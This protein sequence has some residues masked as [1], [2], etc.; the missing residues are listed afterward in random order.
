VVNLPCIDMPL[1]NQQD[2]KNHDSKQL[3]AA[4]RKAAFKPFHHHVEQATY[5]E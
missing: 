2:H 5:L 1:A 4:E 3:I